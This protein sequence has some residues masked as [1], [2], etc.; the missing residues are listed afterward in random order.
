[1]ILD[2]F[3][4]TFS[5]KWVGRAMGNEA[6][7]WDGLFRESAQRGREGAVKAVHLSIALRVV[8]RFS[9]VGDPTQQASRSGIGGSQ[10]LLVG[11]GIS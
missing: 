4:F 1:V 9:I 7:N 5:I 3:F 11:H 10:T 8:W 2:F 6:S